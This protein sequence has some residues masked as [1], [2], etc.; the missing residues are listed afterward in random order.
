MT[1]SYVER[2]EENQRFFLSKE[3]AIR[4]REVFRMRKIGTSA[5]IVTDRG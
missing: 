1:G 5:L 3:L 4:N 2:G